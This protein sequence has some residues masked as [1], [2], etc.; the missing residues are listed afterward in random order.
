MPERTGETLSARSVPAIPTFAVYIP[1]RAIAAQFSFARAGT[2]PGCFIRPIPVFK[3]LFAAYFAEYGFGA[4]YSF[5]LLQW[6]SSL[7]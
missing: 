7:T 1:F 5:I 6:F 2:Y 3:N 4:V